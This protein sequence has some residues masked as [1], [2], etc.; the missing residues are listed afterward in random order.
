MY[1][2]FPCRTDYFPRPSPSCRACIR[3]ESPW[4]H[5][6]RQ[7]LHRA[8]QDALSRAEAEL[9]KDQHHAVGRGDGDGV[10]PLQVGGSAH[11]RT[12]HPHRDDA[13][14]RLLLVGHEAGN[15]R[16]PLLPPRGN[17]REQAEK[18]DRK[19]QMQEDGVLLFHVGSELLYHRK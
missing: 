6:E 3:R 7:F 2:A 4:I 17:C 12:L 10:T 14:R 13:Q 1:R 5:V 19:K 18:G 8:A 15:D 9:G 16:R 11:G